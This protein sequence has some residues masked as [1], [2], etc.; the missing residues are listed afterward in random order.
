MTLIS[1]RFRRLIHQ[2]LPSNTFVQEL[3]T[4]VSYYQHPQR[5]LLLQLEFQRTIYLIHIFV[6]TMG[7]NIDDHFQT[8]EEILAK[9]LRKHVQGFF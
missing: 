3:P 4:S 8:I 1:D 2:P 7:V 6:S 9:P 5:F